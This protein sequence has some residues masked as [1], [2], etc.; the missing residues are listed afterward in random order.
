MVHEIID[1]KGV[2]YAE[3]RTFVLPIDVFPSV[4]EVCRMYAGGRPYIVE[5]VKVKLMGREFGR[6]VLDVYNDD[7]MYTVGLLKD[8]NVDQKNWIDMF[9]DIVN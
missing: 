4:K 7:L 8:H 9:S 6:Y 3:R 5:G 1:M 2:V